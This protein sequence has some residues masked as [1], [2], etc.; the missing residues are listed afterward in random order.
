MV[1]AKPKV[2]SGYQ[3]KKKTSLLLI[4]IHFM[5][6]PLLCVHV[7]TCPYI[8]VFPMPSALYGFLFLSDSTDGS[9]RDGSHAPRWK[10]TQDTGTHAYNTLIY[11][12]DLYA[13]VQEKSCHTQCDTLSHLWWIC[14]PLQHVLN[15]HGWCRTS[16]KID[17]DLNRE[18]KWTL[19]KQINLNLSSRSLSRGPVAKVTQRRTI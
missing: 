9:Y 15:T 2:Q 7:S 8:P 6:S 19:M 4:C 10:H 5:H 13:S 16:N 12:A 14:E 17:I 3:V 18:E 1:K 11:I